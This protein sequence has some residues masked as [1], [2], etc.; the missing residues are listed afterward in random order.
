[1]TI[2]PKITSNKNLLE[3]I[4]V[5]HFKYL[6]AVFTNEVSLDTEVDAH[7]KK[8]SMAFGCLNKLV[9]YNQQ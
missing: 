3:K 8:A 1:M 4:A 2:L 9:W 6:G 5:K 7:V